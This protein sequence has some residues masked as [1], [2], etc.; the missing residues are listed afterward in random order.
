MLQTLSSRQ[1][2]WLIYVLLAFVWGSSFIL[3]MRGLDVFSAW[4]VGAIRL[5][6]AGLVMLPLVIH[7]IKEVPREKWKYIISIGILGNA[8]P[9]V[10]FPLAELHINSASAGVLNSLSSVFTLV[11]GMLFFGLQFTR[12]RVLGVFIGLI[13]AAALIL[14]GSEKLDAHE[15][16]PYA[17]L[18]VVATIGYG[19]STNII[20]KYLQDVPTLL[21]SG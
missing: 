12:F 1:Q 9:A 5:V 10:L 2:A 16:I 15:H 18:A 8:L 19:L 11:L 17:L 20:K 21:A 7:R 4:E 13:G 3:I 14:G 6:I